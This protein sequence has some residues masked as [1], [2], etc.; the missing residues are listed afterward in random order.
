MPV[1]IKII[2][3]SSNDHVSQCCFRAFQFKTKWTQGIWNIHCPDD[4]WGWLLGYE[5]LGTKA[6]FLFH[7]TATLLKALSRSYWTQSHNNNLKKNSQSSFVLNLTIFRVTVSAKWF[8]GFD[9]GTNIFIT[10]LTSSWILLK[11]DVFNISNSVGPLKS[12]DFKLSQWYGVSKDWSHDQP[13]PR[14]AISTG[15]NISAP[16]VNIEFQPN[17]LHGGLQAPGKPLLPGAAG[18]AFIFTWYEKK[19]AD[20]LT[21]LPQHP[22]FPKILRHPEYPFFCKFFKLL[23]RS[24]PSPMSKKFIGTLGSDLTKNMDLHH[25]PTLH[26]EVKRYAWWSFSHRV[27]IAGFKMLFIYLSESFKDR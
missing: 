13:M 19:I 7:S 5:F 24:G 22:A 16:I 6:W 10:L 23:W 27:Q 20:L 12:L 3:I 26:Y 8:S 14:T 1:I 25:L 9:T 21:I 11:V 2:C 15:R 4:V 17:L 18:Q